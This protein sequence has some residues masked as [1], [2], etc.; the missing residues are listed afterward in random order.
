LFKGIFI[1]Y[2]TQLIQHH[3]LDP[4]RKDRYTEF[5]FRN[6]EALWQQGTDKERMLYGPYW[7]EKPE[8][9]VDLT[10]HLSGSMLIEA[11]AL[12]DNAGYQE[13]SQKQQL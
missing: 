11:A 10:I 7:K 2:F 13:K 8:G 9:P 5:V 4:D 1:R 12:L 3:A 6:A